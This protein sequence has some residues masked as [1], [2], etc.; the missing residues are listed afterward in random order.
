MSLKKI[1]LQ[2]FIITSIMVDVHAT[3]LT[4]LQ[5]LDSDSSE[6][7]LPKRELIK[8]DITVLINKNNIIVGCTSGSL[9]ITKVQQ[10]SKK[11]VS[12]NDYI[13]GSHLQ[14]GDILV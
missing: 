13:R 10:P 1:F 11:E 4:H 12:V 5:L 3:E 9:I 7:V 8:N 6:V 14:V 2:F